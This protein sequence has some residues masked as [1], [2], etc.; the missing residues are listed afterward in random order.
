ML[1][2]LCVWDPD[3][4]H[5]ILY[6]SCLKLRDLNPIIAWLTFNYSMHAVKMYISHNDS[7]SHE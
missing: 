3:L 4:D 2:N 5:S 7:I 6:A 1:T